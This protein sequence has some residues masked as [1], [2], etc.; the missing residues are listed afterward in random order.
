MKGIIGSWSLVG[1]FS[2]LEDHVEDTVV[3]F[4]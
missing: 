1:D 3:G 2:V 4:I